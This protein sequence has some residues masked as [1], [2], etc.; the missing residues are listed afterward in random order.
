MQCLYIKSIKSSSLEVE[1]PVIASKV[2]DNATKR[3]PEPLAESVPAAPKVVVFHE[4][5]STKEKKP[6]KAKH[7]KAPSPTT[8]VLPTTDNNEDDEKSLRTIFVGNISL[9]ATSEDIKKLFASC[10]KVESV[11]LRS[12]PVAGCAVDQHGKQNLVRKVCANKKIFVEGRD[13]C[14]AY[15]VFA[16]DANASNIEAALALNGTDLFGKKLRVDRKVPTIDP[17]RTVFVGNLAYTVTEDEI[18]AHFESKLEET[19]DDEEGK[20]AV[21]SVRIVR[22][23]ESHLAKGF[24]YVLLRVRIHMHVYIYAI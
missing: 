11:R 2:V 15:V 23:K 16:N 17:K 18:R 9:K 7:S 21:E 20:S 4:D 22:D 14:N 6:R 24:G 5:A 8:P 1:M 12:L 10:G 19:S 13:N 3:L